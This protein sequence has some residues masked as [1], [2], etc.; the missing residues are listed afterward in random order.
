M[1]KEKKGKGFEAQKS[2]FLMSAV[3]RRERNIKRVS[4]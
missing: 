2:L 3:W 4:L 1:K